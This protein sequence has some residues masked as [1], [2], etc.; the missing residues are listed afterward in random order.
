MRIY[1][2]YTLWNK[3]AHVPW[4]CD[5]IRTT[6]PKDTV[7]DFVLDN[8][9]DS[10]EKNLRD[11]LT[12][13]GYGGLLGFKVLIN[14]GRKFRWPNTNDALVRFL[15]SDCTHFLSPQDDQQIQDK[16]I[17]EN[18]ASV[19]TF[20]IL[21]MRDGIDWEGNYFS[22][23]FSKG[24]DKTTWLSSGDYKKVR[25]VNDGPIF[26]SREVVERVGFFD[27]GFIAHYADNDYSFRC[28]DAGYDNYVMGAEI[29]H[30][31]WGCK[32]CGEIQPSEVWTQEVSTHDYTLYKSK[33]PI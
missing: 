4:I 16:K 9:T 5:G 18:I 19:P 1:L 23:N 6:M 20:G 24:T 2:H 29:V 27:E 10:T 21:G 7:L 3:A 22:S 30:E 15:K 12:H 8:C 11:C 32:V 31:K 13:G 14:Q 26:I 33:W 25:F 17:F 28:N